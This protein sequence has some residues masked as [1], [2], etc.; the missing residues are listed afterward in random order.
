MPSDSAK[1]ARRG[2][3]DEVEIAFLLTRLG[4][5]HASAMTDL[6]R[7]LD[8]RPKQFGL[9]NLVALGDGPS[10]GEIGAQMEIDP[11]GLISTLDEL[12]ERGW[13]ERRR[14]ERDRRRHALHL[15]A[16]GRRK[17]EQARAAA[18]GRAADLTAPLSAAERKELLA[19]L[20]KL[21]D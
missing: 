19:L 13:L 15:T 2:P 14:D 17:L 11:S 1:G 10:Q 4:S 6:L 20:R 7:P 3:P 21:A 18:R 12:E 8:L 16:A 5:R 9:M